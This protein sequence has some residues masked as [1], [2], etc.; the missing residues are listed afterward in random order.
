MLASLMSARRFWPLFWSQF[1]SAFNDNFIKQALIVLAVY[2]IAQTAPME[3]SNS[4][5][6]LASALLV[7]PG[8]ILSGLA[9][10][11]ADRYDKIG[12]AHV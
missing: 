4:L 5:V 7:A 10:Q 11:M 2:G 9:G 1:F 6:S 12:R 3:G 8:L